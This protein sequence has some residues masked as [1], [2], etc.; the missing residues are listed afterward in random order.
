MLI[1]EIES[2]TECLRARTHTRREQRRKTTQ[3]CLAL[4]QRP[5][6]EPVGASEKATA[7]LD[8]LQRRTT[9]QTTPRYAAM[10]IDISMGLSS[11]SRRQ[12]EAKA[13]ARR[14]SKATGVR[15]C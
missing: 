2:K 10:A 3:C 4:R 13:F 14:H 7:R 8:R 12:F 11:P 6:W 9:S 5:D 1:G 15:S